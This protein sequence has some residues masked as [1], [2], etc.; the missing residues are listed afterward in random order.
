LLRSRR[1][2]G[3]CFGRRPLRRTFEIGSEPRGRTYNDLLYRAFPWCA[4]LWLVVVPLPGSGD[5]LLPRAHVVLRELEPHLSAATD[6]TEWPG[7]RLETGTARV[8]RYRLHPEVL[9]VVAGAT[10][11][12]YGW[13]HPEL[14]QDLA[15]VRGDGTPFLA[16]VTNEDWAALTLDDEER[17]VLSGDLPEL[18]LRDL[19]S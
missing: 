10:D 4:E 12:L 6:E 7:T 1:G 5:P 8:H 19:W 14:P 15:L 16:T 17:Q 9:D 2:L 13:R 11:H 18:S 3:S